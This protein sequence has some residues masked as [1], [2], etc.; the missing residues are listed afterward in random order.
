MAAAVFTLVPETRLGDK[1]TVQ[2][3]GNLLAWTG[4]ITL[5]PGDTYTTGGNSFA[6]KK[7]PEDM[8]KGIG[9]GTVL[10]FFVEGATVQWDNTAKKLKVTT[11]TTPIA[12]VTN[13][14][15]LTTLNNARVTIIGR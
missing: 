14:A 9:A 7:G 11:G 5:T 1:A 13:G 2:K 3:A 10:H 6:S 12:E 15:V 4:T 8:L